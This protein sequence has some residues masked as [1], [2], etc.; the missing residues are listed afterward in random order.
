MFNA[1]VSVAMCVYNG[2]E[3]LHEQLESIVEQTHRP[4]EI[5]VCDDCSNDAS[6]KIALS[7][8]TS[9]PDRFKI[10]INQHN[11]GFTR[12]FEKALNSCSKDIVFLSDQDD[13]WFP[14]K[15]ETLTRIFF[16][17]KSIAGITH[18]GELVNCNLF[19]EGNTKRSQI[20]R[21]Y[22]TSDRT[23]TGA[24]SALRREYLEILLP[25]PEGIIGHDTWFTYVFSIFPRRWL[26]YDHSLQKIRRHSDNTSE[27][28][29]NSITKIGRF[30]AFKS[31]LRTIPA[32]S[33][34]NRL[35]MNSALTSRL[36]RKE[37]ATRLFSHSEISDARSFLTAERNAIFHR[38]SLVDSSSKLDRIAQA[39]K[40][41]S[42]NEYQYFN[43]YKS[44]L[45]D[46]LR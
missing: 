29:V 30:H 34:D 23:I 5:I 25:I 27:W 7:F 2:A 15:I 39:I 1:D 31:Q 20:K 45:R 38:Q 21:A 10:I 42:K 6:E 12:N 44:F 18:D 35:A 43:G 41:R 19:G 28:V 33:Y 8:K 17:K 11:V 4:A 14:E 13:V 40:M 22:G 36:A 37:I 24:L 3:F 26:F 46:L 9:F 32:N 16:D